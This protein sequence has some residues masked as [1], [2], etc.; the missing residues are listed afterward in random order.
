MCSR[1]CHAFYRG[2]LFGDEQRDIVDHARARGAEQAAE[3]ALAA[4][5]LGEYANLSEVLRSIPMDPAPG[6][7]DND[8]ARRRRLRR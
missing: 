8:R 3:R 6:R 2:K 4:L 7:T 5:P 1:R